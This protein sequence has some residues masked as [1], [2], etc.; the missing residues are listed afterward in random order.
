MSCDG[1]LP[2]CAI[3]EQF[4]NRAISLLRASRR[5]SV[6]GPPAHI[7]RPC[8]AMWAAVTTVPPLCDFL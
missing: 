5:S 4:V 6:H 3:C 7:H 1:W 8:F 2:R